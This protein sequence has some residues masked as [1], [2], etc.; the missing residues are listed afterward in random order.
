MELKTAIEAL[1]ALAHDTRLNVFRLLVRAGQ[2][3]LSAGDIAASLGVPAPTL[4]FHLAQLDRAGLVA[5]RRD[6]RSI[7]YR[8]RFDAVTRLLEFLMEDCC[9][10]RATP[11][12]AHSQTAST[13]DCNC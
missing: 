9:Q 7:I 10:G 2:D 12:A 3:G 1:S 6:G 11:N 8:V 13:T 5:S 4:S